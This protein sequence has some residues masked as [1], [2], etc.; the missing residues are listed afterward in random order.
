MN[1]AIVYAILCGA[2]G[3]NY[4][5]TKSAA[6]SVF[7][8]LSAVDKLGEC[9]YKEYSSSEAL[10]VDVEANGLKFEVYTDI[11][12]SLRGEKNDKTK[13]VEELKEQ[14]VDNPAVEQD[15]TPYK[16]CK[17]DIIPVRKGVWRWVVKCL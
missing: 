3:Y 1:S 8:G 6:D 13:E 5:S 2:H 10:D 7:K 9:S 15:N 4:S 14:E 11:L 12:A 17:S 16:V